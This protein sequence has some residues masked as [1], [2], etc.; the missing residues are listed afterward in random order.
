ME[1]ST[2]E[3]ATQLARLAAQVERLQ[4]DVAALR[5]VLLG[6]GAQGGLVAAV[7]R[8]QH[9]VDLLS[10]EA[11]LNRMR[12]W[13]FRLALYGWMVSAILAA[14]AAALQFLRR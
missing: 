7:N 4:A 8:L 1:L 9:A 6:D 2:L 10:R 14:L 13:Q 12:G 3:L 11:E 5:L